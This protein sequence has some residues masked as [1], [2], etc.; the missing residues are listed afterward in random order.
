MGAHRRRRDDAEAEEECDAEL[1]AAE[2]TIHAAATHRDTELAARA[3]AERREHRR[4]KD[5]AEETV[6]VEA[7]LAEAEA[8]RDVQVEAAERDVAERAAHWAAEME[9]ALAYQRDVERREGGRRAAAHP[10][11]QRRMTLRRQDA[12]IRAAMV[13][14]CSAGPVNHGNGA[15]HP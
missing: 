7:A 11:L 1:H 12:A 15:A 9:K 13:A 5:L 4:G 2:G 10:R 8:K 6:V 14:I 3:A